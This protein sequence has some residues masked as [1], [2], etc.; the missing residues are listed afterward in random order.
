MSEYPLTLEGIVLWLKS[1]ARALDPSTI[2]LKEIGERRSHVP[3]VG[4][5]FDSPNAMGRIN[6]W[7]CG[8]FDFEVLRIA[9]GESVLFR[10]ETAT[11]LDAAILDD[12]FS[13]FVQAMMN[14]ESTIPR[15]PPQGS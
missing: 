8:Q 2:K 15:K 6:V 3:A 12:A 7:V 11:A 10:H 1:N 13:Q 5:D 9:D 4:A 14:P